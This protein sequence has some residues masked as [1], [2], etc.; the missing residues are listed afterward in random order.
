MILNRQAR[1]LNVTIRCLFSLWLFLGCIELLEQLQLVPETGVENQTG[2]DPDEDA[3]VALES[4]LKSDVLLAGDHNS[5]VIVA[6]VEPTLSVS[7][8]T[9]D[10]FTRQSL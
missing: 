10:P 2:L 3:L 9:F 5:S 8:A 1:V 6:S 7:F 4:G